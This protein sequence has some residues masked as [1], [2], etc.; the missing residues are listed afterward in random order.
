MGSCG[1]C[2]ACN[3]SGFLGFCK[4]VPAGASDPA[5]TC[6]TTAPTSCGT[7]GRCDGA[8]GCRFHAAGTVCQPAGCQ[9]SSFVRQ[10]VCNGQG[11]CTD[12]G[13]TNCF[14][15]LCDSGSN[16][17]FTSCTNDNQ[18]ATRCREFLQECQ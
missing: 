9:G 11:V 12:G 1:S 16:G 15:Y 13:S 14:P 10:D 2:R 7:D 17:C 5:G 3:V 18:C 6:Q 4:E 8:G